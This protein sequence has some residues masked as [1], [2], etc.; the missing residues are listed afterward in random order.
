LNNNGINPGGN[1]P[2]VP[3]YVWTIE[4]VQDTERPNIEKTSREHVGAPYEER[5]L[6]RLWGNGRAK[7]T[8]TALNP[9][10]NPYRELM[11]DQVTGSYLEFEYRRL[12]QC[13]DKANKAVVAS[14]YPDMMDLEPLIEA[15]KVDVNPWK[16]VRKDRIKEIRSK[17]T[18]MAAEK[19][20]EAARSNATKE[21]HRE[22]QEEA[23]SGL[24]APLPEGEVLPDD[25]PAQVPARRGR[26]PRV[27]VPV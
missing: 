11:V 24:S 22:A 18:T 8:R 5:I 9:D 13:F 27:A 4:P 26:P 10:L 25:T 6:R 2:F 16:E 7:I 21:A 15:C 23:M 1:M 19:L 20:M 3:L 17:A 14:V 12:K